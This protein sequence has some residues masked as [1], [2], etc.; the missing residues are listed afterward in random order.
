VGLNPLQDARNQ[1]RARLGG[2]EPSTEYGVYFEQ[3]ERLIA[4]LGWRLTDAL[5]FYL[6]AS[7]SKR[8]TTDDPD[9]GPRALSQMFVSDTVPGFGSHTWLAYVEAAIR[10]DSRKTVARPSPGVLIETYAGGA[11]DIM[12]YDDIAFTRLGF[13]AAGY[14]P[15]YRR[16]NILSPRI[17]VDRAIPRGGVEIPFY[18]L[19]RQPDFR[20]FD[21]R[22]DGVSVITS[23]DYAWELVPFMGMRIF[24]DGATVAPGLSDLDVGNLV[25]MRYA[26]GLGIDLFMSNAEL[27]RLTVAFSG[28]GVNVL[29]ALG[30]SPRYGDRQHR[31]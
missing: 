9:A 14:I 29:F 13:R 3:R 2:H 6:S 23:L 5:Q 7:I 19:P 26:A 24:A 4:G 15:F 20:G 30:V 17:V 8:E 10:F 22:R 25:Q 16:R 1:Y 28:E 21:R 11:Q 27:G 12:G 31:N 18:E